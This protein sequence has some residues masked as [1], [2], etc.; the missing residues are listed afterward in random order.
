MPPLILASHR[1]TA[2][3][4]LHGIA[5]FFTIIAPKRI[6]TRYHQ[7]LWK[8]VIRFVNFSLGRIGDP[9]P[10][11]LGRGSTHP[12]GRNRLEPPTP[13]Q[14]RRLNPEP[15]PDCV[16]AGNM[17]PER[18]AKTQELHHDD[19]R[20]DRPR[21]RVDPAKVN[22]FKFAAL[23]ITVQSAA[24]SAAVDE[25]HSH[26][27]ALSHVVQTTVEDLVSR[28][29]QLETKRAELA[30]A[31]QS[32]Q[33]EVDKL[34]KL[35]ADNEQLIQQLQLS[36]LD[37]TTKAT[38]LSKKLIDLENLGNSKLGEI[39]AQL[40]DTTLVDKIAE[41]F[42]NVQELATSVGALKQ[43]MTDKMSISKVYRMK[44]LL[45]E[46]YG[47][48]YSGQGKNGSMMA[49]VDKTVADYPGNNAMWWTFQEQH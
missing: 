35:I 16:A 2:T 32:R 20:P 18:V 41:T 48:V 47:S 42:R 45:G 11:S 34:K 24:K 40:K 8:W 1:E 46:W 4:I 9:C 27:D 38:V 23:W 43:G 33:S 29:S 36:I 15:R 21:A 39:A 5:P 30:S 25:V 6:T 12:P 3:Y 13:D 19:S 28:V 7:W 44:S 31:M 22:R 26:F 14:R 10:C 49:I 17:N 37:E